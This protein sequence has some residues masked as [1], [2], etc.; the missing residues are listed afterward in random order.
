MKTVERIAMG[1]RGRELVAAK[2]AWPAISAEMCRVCEWTVGGGAPPASV[3][4]K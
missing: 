4:L 3:R 1:A 2:F